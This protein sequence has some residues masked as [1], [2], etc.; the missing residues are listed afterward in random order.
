[1]LSIKLKV[2]LIILIIDENNENSFLQL[3]QIV[4]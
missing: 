1:M 4:L 3:L 2:F